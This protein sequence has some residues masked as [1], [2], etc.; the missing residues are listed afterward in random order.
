MRIGHPAVAAAA[1]DDGAAWA[2]ER[3]GLALE[4]GGRHDRFGSWNRLLSLGPGLDPEVIAPEPGTAPA[5][6]RWFGIDAAGAPARRHRVTR[7]PDLEAAL[8]DPRL[9]LVAAQAP[10]L[11]ARIATPRGEAAL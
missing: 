4:P 3:L 6:R 11:S 7:G 1:L 2:E 5:R 9:G 8:G 10:G